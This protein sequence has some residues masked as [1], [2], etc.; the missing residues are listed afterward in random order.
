MAQPF[1]TEDE[2]RALHH[3]IFTR[4]WQ[5]NRFYAELRTVREK[6]DQHFGTDDAHLK[7]Q[8]TRSRP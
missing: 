6:L 3:L 7:N 4:P 2:L 5:E 8:P 1:F